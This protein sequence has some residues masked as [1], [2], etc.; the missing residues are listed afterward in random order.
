MNTSLHRET[1]KIY[2]FPIGGRAAFNASR[3]LTQA[4]V[5]ALAP[6]RAARVVYGGNWYHEEALQDDDPARQR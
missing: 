1:A 4:S 6:A 3:R 5:E 2:Q